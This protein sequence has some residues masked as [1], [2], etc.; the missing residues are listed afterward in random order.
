M[1]SLQLFGG[2]VV[3]TGQGPVSGRCAQ[4]HQIALLALL[5]TAPRHTLSRD[6]LIGLLWPDSDTKHARNLLNVSV[7]TIRK[8]LGEDALQSVGD[9]VQLAD[10]RWRVDV[11]EFEAAL[12]ARELERAV[13]RYSGPFLD[14][15]FLA[16]APE[17]NRWQEGERDRLARKCAGVLQSLATSAEAEADPAKAAVWWRRLAAHDPYDSHTALGL[18]RTLARAGNPAAAVHHVQAHATLLRD[19]LGVEPSREV[20]AFAAALWGGAGATGT[21]PA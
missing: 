9:G 5:A 12:A 11:V 18:M 15:F 17:F 10:T 7:Y 8:A 21:A 14:G 19:E 1:I 16:D 3:E 2:A 20:T 4:R 6:K 13:L